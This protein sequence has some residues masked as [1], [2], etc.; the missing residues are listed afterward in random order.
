MVVCGETTR[1]LKQTNTKRRGW[2]DT[3][4]F[5]GKKEA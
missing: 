3:K 2:K 4:G 5:E 1:S